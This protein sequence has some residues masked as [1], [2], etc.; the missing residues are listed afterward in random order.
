MDCLPDIFTRGA[1]ST[2]HH[3]AGV[4]GTGADGMYS[5]RRRN[6]SNSEGSG[7]KSSSS[8]NGSSTPRKNVAKCVITGKV[9]RY[10]DP[11]TMLGYHD[12]NAY[13]ELRRRVDAG[14]L[15]PLPSRARATKSNGRR[16]FP[17]SKDKPTMTATLKNASFDVKVMVTQNGVP[18]SPPVESKPNLLVVN[19]KWMGLPVGVPT[20]R[21][22]PLPEDF[23]NNELLESDSK[24]AVAKEVDSKAVVAQTNSKLEKSNN[25]V[26]SEST[27]APPMK[28]N[29]GT[30]CHTSENVSARL[31]PRRV[32]PTPNML[33][34]TA[35]SNSSLPTDSKVVASSNNLVSIS[36]NNVDKSNNTSIPTSSSTP[37]VT[38]SNAKTPAI[39]PQRMSTR[40][41]KPTSKVLPDSPPSNNESNGTPKT[42]QDSNQ[43]NATTELLQTSNGSSKNNIDTT[44]NNKDSRN[45]NS[46]R[47][48]LSNSKKIIA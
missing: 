18:V 31:S 36:N 48:N 10:R 30:H 16:H 39:I 1:S 23:L 32:K 17:F 33:P 21:G 20:K 34:D 28:N 8:E 40:K 13:K 22:P 29:G 2:V 46:D 6:R 42:S 38:T 9:A 12:I 27:D 14:E 4:G 43:K 11:Q 37:P 7:G 26:I 45:G 5:P 19:D 47:T 41:H 25:S 3:A 24:V 35:P 15:R 44:T